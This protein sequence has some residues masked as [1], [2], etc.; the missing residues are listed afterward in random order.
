MPEN[1]LHHRGAAQR[2]C[3]RRT[4][5]KASKRPQ[6]RY[7]CVCVCVCVRICVCVCVR[8]CS[9]VCMYVRVCACVSV[10]LFVCVRVH[11]CA[12]V[13]AHTCV[14][15]CACVRACVLTCVCLLHPSPAVLSVGPTLGS[16]ARWRPPLPSL[17]AWGRPRALSGLRGV[18]AG[19]CHPAVPRTHAPPLAL[20]TTLRTHTQ[21][22]AQQQARKIRTLFQPVR[23]GVYSLELPTEYKKVQC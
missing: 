19:G 3:V 13:R 17:G 21:R 5:A 4:K 20:M 6:A 8:A 22:G 10:C 14:C 15:V 11:V 23:T 18:S 9:C 1:S 16:Q 12:C 2:V 7:V